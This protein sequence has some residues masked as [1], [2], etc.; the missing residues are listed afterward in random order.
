MR[1]NIILDFSFNKYQIYYKYTV[2]TT[3]FSVI[4]FLIKELP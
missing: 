3:K 2:K 1:K 4:F